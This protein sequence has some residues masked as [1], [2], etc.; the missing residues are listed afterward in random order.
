MASR[1]P[2]KLGNAAER[3]GGREQLVEIEDAQQAGA[4]ERGVIDRVGAG[5][6][7]GVRHRR[8]GALR[9]PSRFD[10]EHRLGPRRRARRRHELARIS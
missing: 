7:A 3:L 1:L 5:E 6:R 4:A 9:V 10:H 8:F 2:A